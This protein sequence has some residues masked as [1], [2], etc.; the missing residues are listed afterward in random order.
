MGWKIQC[1]IWFSKFPKSKMNLLAHTTVP[2]SGALMYGDIFANYLNLTI[3]SQKVFYIKNQTDQCKFWWVNLSGIYYL[4]HGQSGFALY[5]YIYMPAP[6]LGLGHI[7]Q[8]NLS[9]PCYNYYIYFRL[10]VCT[11]LHY[12]YDLFL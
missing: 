11:L 4:Y 1:K 12:G 2:L 6:A 8:P 10:I 9:W 3:K 5:I 7:Y